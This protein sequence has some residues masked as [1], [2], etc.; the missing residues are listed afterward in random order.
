MH[1]LTKMGHEASLRRNEKTAENDLKHGTPG[2][3]RYNACITTAIPSS[4]LLRMRHMPNKRRKSAAEHSV[5]QFL[6]EAVF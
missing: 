3:P 4:V 1:I 5:L 2:H 6:H